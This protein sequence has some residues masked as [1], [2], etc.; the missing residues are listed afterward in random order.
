MGNLIYSVFYTKKRKDKPWKYTEQKHL[1]SLNS[2]LS[3]FNYCNYLKPEQNPDFYLIIKCF[4]KRQNTLCIMQ[5]GKVI[6]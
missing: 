2:Y 5:T 1:K 4:S 3:A 6:F